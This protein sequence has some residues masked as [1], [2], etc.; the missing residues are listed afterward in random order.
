MGRA[1]AECRADG[2]AD[3]SWSSRW[4]RW[5]FVMAAG[6]IAPVAVQRAQIQPRA[7]RIETTAGQQDCERGVRLA[8][9]DEAIA[10]EAVVM[11]Q[12]D[13][14]GARHLKDLQ[15]HHLRRGEHL[16]AV[17]DA[18]DAVQPEAVAIAGTVGFP[19]R[20]APPSP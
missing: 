3:M 14:V 11:N 19:R 12:I 2:Q 15:L 7:S 6:V 18:E 20:P 17:H 9:F 1:R 4:D 8:D 16:P 10:V 13:H 5:R